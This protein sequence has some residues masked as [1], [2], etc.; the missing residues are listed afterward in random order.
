MAEVAVR[1]GVDSAHVVFGHTHRAGPMAGE[2]WRLAAGGT[3]VNPGSW[4][5]TEELIAGAGARSPFW[6]GRCVIVED[7]GPPQL[8]DVL[9]EP[10]A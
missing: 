10:A 2:S 7:S 9:E 1:L 3:L 5:H 8:G 4:V 6:P